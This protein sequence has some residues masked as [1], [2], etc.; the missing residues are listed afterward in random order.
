[1]ICRRVSFKHN[2][3]IIGLLFGMPI[4]FKEKI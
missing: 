3:F 2:M 1:M 4:F